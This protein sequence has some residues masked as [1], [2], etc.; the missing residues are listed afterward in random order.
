M[1]NP[2]QKTLGCDLCKS[3]CGCSNCHTGGSYINKVVNDRDD[4]ELNRVLMTSTLE[5]IKRFADIDDDD[6]TVVRY[7]KP[8]PHAIHRV[9]S[10]MGYVVLHKYTD[11]YKALEAKY[12]NAI[13][14]LRSVQQRFSQLIA[15]YE[16]EHFHLVLL[17]RQLRDIGRPV[18]EYVNDIIKL[19][20]SA[21]PTDDEPIEQGPNSGISAMT[22]QSTI[23]NQSM[24]GGGS[25]NNNNNNNS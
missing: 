15:R 4:E 17:A 9:R 12:A 11:E 18:P 10:L 13:M 22:N 3:K 19:Y 25:V 1:W 8:N 20:V 21:D 23:T 14:K 24:A 7:N 2:D 6:V 16:E 5:D